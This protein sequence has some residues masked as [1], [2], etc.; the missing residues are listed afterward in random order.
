MSQ[1]IQSKMILF[2]WVPALLLSCGVKQAAAP[3]I[4]VE[5]V[6]IQDFP[7]RDIEFY[8]SQLFLWPEDVS[9][10]QVS[11]VLDL[12]KNI[13]RLESEITPIKRQLS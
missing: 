1:S 10:S 2:C 12:S 8:S 6:S 4:G 9:H 13:D 11:R 3:K 7:K 5:T